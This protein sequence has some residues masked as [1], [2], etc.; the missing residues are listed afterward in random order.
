MLFGAWQDE[1]TGPSFANLFDALTNAPVRKMIAYN[2][3]HGDGYSPETLVEW[4]A[5]L[6][7]YV[8]GERTP[9]PGFLRQFGPELIGE[10]FNTRL[11]FPDERWLD[12]PF[13]AAKAAFEAE[14]PVTILWDR[15]G[16]S[17]NPGAPES[18]GVSRFTSWPPKTVEPTS[19]FAATDGVLAATKPTS[20][21]PAAR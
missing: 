5:F 14:D 16:R 3:A 6:D 15:G 1:Q 8:A 10:A 12:Q 2:G 20:A 9:I 21:A 19:W 4:K 18:T 11:E 7:F 17:Q 13:A